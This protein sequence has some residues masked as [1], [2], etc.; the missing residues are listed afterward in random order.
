M[1]SVLRM[2]CPACSARS[3]EA[4]IAGP[5]AIGSE[6]GMPSSMMSAPA[7]GSAFRDLERG[8]VVGIARRDE[9]DE[10]RPRPSPLQLAQNAR[11][12]RVAAA[13]ASFTSPCA[14]CSATAK[15]SLSPRPHIFITRRL[16]LRHLRRELRH[17]SERVRRLQRRNDAL[18]PRRRAGRRRAPPCRSTE[19]YF[20]RPVSLSQECSGPTPG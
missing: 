6:K 15:M 5:S 14:R 17:V 16:S 12:I 4:W 13:H 7:P 2:V 8:V 9:G 10:R 11:S 18:Q 3:D 19:T 1:A 20:T